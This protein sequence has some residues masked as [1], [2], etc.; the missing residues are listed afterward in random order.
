MEKRTCGSCTLCCTYLEIESRPGY[1]TRVDNG[2]DLARPAGTP[3]PYLGQSGCAIYL[4]RPPVC[5]QFLCD[6]LEGRKG[7]NHGDS[8]LKTGTIGVRGTTVKAI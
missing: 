1:S 5:R 8:P 2:E 6:W 3:C 7:Y 4:V